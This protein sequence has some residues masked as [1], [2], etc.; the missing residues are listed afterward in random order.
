MAAKAPPAAVVSASAASVRSADAGP[1]SSVAVASACCVEGAA[2]SVGAARPGMHPEVLE[3]RAVDASALPARLTPRSH[4]RAHGYGL[5]AA[6]ARS[7]ADADAGAA[8]ALS[9]MR[10]GEGTTRGSR[11]TPG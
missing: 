3:L 4:G 6:A 5:R 2:A 7:A 8:A 10:A 11:N 1:L 9:L